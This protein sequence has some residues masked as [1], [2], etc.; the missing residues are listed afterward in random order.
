RAAAPVRKVVEKGLREAIIRGDLAPGAHLVDREL[1]D[2]FDVSRTVVRE[3]QRSLEA[4]G[5]VEIIPHRGVFVRRI[6]YDEAQQIYDVRKV[7]EAL[8]GQKCAMNATE[9]DIAELEAVC[10]QLKAHVD[11]PEGVDLL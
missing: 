3:A 5:L 2:M 6:S 9:T 4:E 8:A 10:E 7:L 11:N 1:C